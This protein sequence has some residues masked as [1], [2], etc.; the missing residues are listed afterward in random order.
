MDDLLKTLERFDADLPLAQASTIPGSW[1][2]D[3]KVYEQER[4][5]VFWNS[6]QAIGRTDQV[7]E[8][9]MFFTAD[10]AGE[11]ILVVRNKD[12][13]LRAMSNVCRHRAAR[14]ECRDHGKATRFRCRYH[15]WA[16]DLNGRLAGVPDFDGVENFCKDERPLPPLHV[17]V[18]GPFVFVHLG[19][20]AQTVEEYMR[21]VGARSGAKGVESMQFVARRVYEMRCNWKIFCDNYLDGAYHVPTLH[22]GLAKIVDMDGYHTVIDGNSSV[23]VSPLKKTQGSRLDETLNSVRSGDEAHYWWLWP[24]FMINVYDGTL[25]TNL[26]LPLGVDRCLCIFDFYFNETGTEAAEAYAAKSLAV[27]HQVQLEDQDIC[28]E[29]QRGLS[30]RSYDTGRFSVRRESGGHHFHALLA[31]TL[32]DGL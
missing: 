31:K 20:P 17:G 3:P 16:Y 30:S 1:Y 14:V 23:Q 28:E 25:D 11:P 15:G 2:T 24:N 5:S 10:I 19:Q 4:R 22:P 32:R 21:P 7:R 27:A 18:W 8:P 26:V 13:E 6:W 9:G 12:G 29:V